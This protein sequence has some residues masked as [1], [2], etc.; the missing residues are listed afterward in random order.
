MEELGTEK[1]SFTAIIVAILLI[2]AI[3]AGAWFYLSKNKP[4]DSGVSTMATAPD[5]PAG[6]EQ[7]SEPKGPLVVN[8]KKLE[9]EQQNKMP[10]MTDTSPVTDVQVLTLMNDN[11]IGNPA[12]KVKIIEYSSLTCPHCAA[13][14]KSSF[15][16][17]KSE[18]IDTGRVRM[19]FRE[20]PL[21]PP[22]MDASM[23]LRCMPKDKFMNFMNL[24]FDEQEKW[25]FDAN[26]TDKL[27]QSAKL[28]GMTDTAFDAC[29][30][31][32]ELKK[33][34]AQGMKDANTKFKVQSTPSFV[35]NDGERVIVGNQSIEFFETAIA[36]AEKNAPPASAS[37]GGSNGNPSAIKE[38]EAAAPADTAPAAAAPEQAPAE[39]ETPPAE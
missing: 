28:A 15:E 18:F 16:K 3:G 31:N 14:H 30:A 37:R 24:L 5:Q 29:L 17:F 12:A 22:A 6:T 25:A 36:E 13:F 27:R 35:I 32:N 7:S 2:V 20:F 1:K 21:N 19:A 33:A 23:V 9:L 38:H 34:L 26:Y 4:V 8:T 39:T 11:W 10:D